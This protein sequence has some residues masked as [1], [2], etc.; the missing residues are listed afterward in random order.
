MEKLARIDALSEE[1]LQS[2]SASELAEIRQLL[3]GTLQ[4]RL[5]GVL[6]DHA[7]L[8]ALQR[9]SSRDILD[10]GEILSP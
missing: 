4:S 6:A 9:E 2:A 10:D 3:L 8:D 5:Q 7:Q 1:Q